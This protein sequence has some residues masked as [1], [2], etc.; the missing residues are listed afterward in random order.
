M[1]QTNVH[2]TNNHR[3]TCNYCYGKF[4]PKRRRVQK[5]CSDSCRSKAYHQ[6]TTTKKVATLNA[7]SEPAPTKKK[8][9]I[10]KMSFAGIGNAAAGVVAV[11]VLSRILTKDEDRP[12]TK[13]DL[14]KISQH[15][16]RYHRINNLEPDHYGK[17]PYFDMDKGMLVYFFGEVV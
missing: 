8:T 7:P 14:Q 16:K 2:D 10:E 13:G 9:K 6:R 1:R 5:Y 15:L 4:I 12:A 17:A 3:Y 11:D